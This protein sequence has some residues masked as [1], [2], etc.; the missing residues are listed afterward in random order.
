MSRNKIQMSSYIFDRIHASALAHDPHYLADQNKRWLAR[1]DEAD[2]DLMV[3]AEVDVLAL[4]AKTLAISIKNGDEIYFCFSGMATPEQLPVNLE[5]AEPTPGL[6]ACAVYCA[7]LKALGTASQAKDILEQQYHGQAGYSGHELR[8]IA[9]LFQKL[10]F[11]RVSAGA[12]APYFRELERVAGAYITAGYPGHPLEFDSN[13]QSRLLALFESGADTIPFSLPLQGLL[14][15]SWPSLFLDLYRCLE[16]LYTALKLK[17]L[18]G[19]I[20]HNGSLAD[21]AYLLEDELSWRPKE[22]DALAS[23]LVLSSDDTRSKILSAF[24]FNVGE[25]D[26]YSPSKCARSI[27]KLRNSHVHFRPAMKAES[28][29][30]DQWNEIMIAMCDAVDDIYEKL[31]VEFLR[32]RP[33]SISTV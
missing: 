30:S 24:K 21:L 33:G 10:Y 22:Q 31:G 1:K 18:V 25:L 8:D 17:S 20:S 16:Q 15:Y 9:P 29:S 23:I 3:N 5:E 19:K 27:Y 14:S 26:E 4:G 2:L 11:V 32:D 13:L 12:R 6:F 28:K 7:E